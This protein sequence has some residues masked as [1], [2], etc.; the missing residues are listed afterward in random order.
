MQSFEIFY[1]EGFEFE[2]ETW[3]ASFLYSFD[4][5][6]FFEEKIYFYDANFDFE[7]KGSNFWESETFLFSLSLA[8]GI[9]YYK[10]FPTKKL[11]V[12]TWFLDEAQK[13]FWK[14]FYINWL[15]E[16]FY[17]NKL[18]YRE[19]GNFES[20]SQKHI[21]KSLQKK[22]QNKSL[23]PIG[24][25][26]D[27]IVSS[28]ILEQNKKN[29]TPFI[30]WKKDDIKENQLKII[31]KQAIFIKRELSPNL[32]TLTKQGYYNGH[33]PISGIISFVSLFV[34]YLY[35][36]KN[37]IFSNEKSANS[38]NTFL[39]ELEIN[40]Q[41]SKSLDF[42]GKLRDYIKLYISDEIEYFSLLRGFYEI[43][44]ASF[45]ASFWKKY[46]SSFSSCNTNFKINQEQ[47]SQK[48]WC[49]TCPKCVFVYSILRP[50]LSEQ[51][52][53]EIFWKELYQ[54]ETLEN[55]FLEIWGWK[56]FK[57][58]ECV[59]EEEEARLATYLFLEKNPDFTSNTLSIFRE[60]IVI[61]PEKY[62]E[63]LKKKYFT[64]DEKDFI[65]KEFKQLLRNI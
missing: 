51:E 48:L 22:L 26:K 14:D 1:F 37:I 40:H 4:K 47:K 2:Q 17:R 31:Q 52:N 63:N 32:F 56:D 11:I 64:L 43:K 44:I 60:R 30:F 61:L 19:Y 6:E 55:L 25:G 33:I 50:F 28:E 53:S 9:S 45:F 41:Y 62:F 39:W 5:Q 42:E 10:L 12:E 8:L 13:D 18:D 57:P 54:D 34:A 23:L 16:F 58:F 46:F 35:D 36:Y 7:R 24:W 65:P 49:N 3:V 38:G 15:G 29:Y 20:K 21:Q 27:S 59:G